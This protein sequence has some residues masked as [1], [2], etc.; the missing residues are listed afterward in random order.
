MGYYSMKLDDEARKRC[1][2]LLPWGLYSYNMLP[3]G[4]AVATDVFQ[5][6]MGELFNNISIASTES[7][8]KSPANTTN[9]DQHDTI[10]N[11]VMNQVQ[12]SDKVS[13]PL[14]RNPLFP[15]VDPSKIGTTSQYYTNHVNP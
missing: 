9:K 11:N 1:V 5:E 3:M 10:Y 2:T 4:I 15:N 14:S 7:T 13:A 12:S 6:A 8:S